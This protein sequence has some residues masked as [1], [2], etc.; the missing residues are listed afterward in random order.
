MKPKRNTSNNPW[1]YL[2]LFCCDIQTDVIDSV[3]SR[4]DVSLRST[5]YILE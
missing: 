1:V 2:T 4:F 5:E 3:D